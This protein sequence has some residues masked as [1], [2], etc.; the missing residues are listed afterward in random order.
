MKRRGFLR[1]LGLG[2]AATALPAVWPEGTAPAI[3]E[4]AGPAPVNLPF[5]TSGGW[6]NIVWD[7]KRRI[8]IA[9]DLV[10]STDGITWNC[11][12]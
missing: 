4:A 1:V 5:V 6:H 2:A 8:F 12:P 7:S 10:Q 11:R 3:V 9:D